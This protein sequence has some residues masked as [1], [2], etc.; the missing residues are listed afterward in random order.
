M[1]WGAGALV[2][3]AYQLGRLRVGW[4]GA[5]KSRLWPSRAPAAAEPRTSS[6]IISLPT[7]SLS[8]AA[9]PCQPPVARRC[10]GLTLRTGRTLP[11]HRFIDAER[12]LS[13]ARVPVACRPG[14][15]GWV[16]SESKF[17]SVVDHIPPP[18]LCAENPRGRSVRGFATAAC[19][20]PPIRDLL[21]EHE[22]AGGRA[23]RPA[24]EKGVA[25]HPYPSAEY[26]TS[27]SRDRRRIKITGESRTAEKKNCPNII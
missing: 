15:S 25:G 2:V 20:L 4:L 11:A 18:I 19:P 23:G 6:L 14:I 22:R 16:R 12:T 5:I 10:H 27:S 21:C 9:L 7:P 13:L 17:D 8:I 3:W 1:G 26:S 24:M